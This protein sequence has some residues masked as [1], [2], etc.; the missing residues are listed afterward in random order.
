[1]GA[2]FHPHLGIVPLVL[3]RVRRRLRPAGDLDPLLPRTTDSR[4]SKPYPA[5]G[6]AMSLVHGSHCYGKRIC[7]AL[8]LCAAGGATAVGQ[9][10]SPCPDAGAGTIKGIQIHL[11]DA[12][13]APPEAIELL[14]ANAP[15]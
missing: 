10:D 3:S 2:L 11:T 15:Q 14:R 5:P 13:Q 8:L 9:T 7:I 1:M 6:G 12:T 4:W